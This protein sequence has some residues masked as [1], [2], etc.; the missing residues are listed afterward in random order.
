[1]TAPSLEARRPTCVNGV[2]VACAFKGNSAEKKKAPELTFER[3]HFQL[4]KLVISVL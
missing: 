3:V 2:A 1:M 4:V